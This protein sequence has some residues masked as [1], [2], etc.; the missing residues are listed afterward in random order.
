MIILVTGANGHLGI[1][2]RNVTAASCDNYIFSDATSLPDVETRSL[3]ITDLDALR[4]VCDSKKVDVIANCAAYTDVDKAEDDLS[5]A[6]LRLT[7]EN[8]TLKIVSDQVG[9]PTYARYL[10]SLIAKIIREMLL[11]KTKVKETFGISIP[12]WK[13]SLADCIE[14]IKK[15][16]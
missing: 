11:D 5:T 6:I 16:E 4:I 12:Y 7:E 14:R 13:D 2:L 15:A 9:T 3:D 1:V 8:D 10:T